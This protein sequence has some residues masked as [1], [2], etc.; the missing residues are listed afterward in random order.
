MDAPTVSQED[1]DREHRRQRADD[2]RRLA[3]RLTT[4]E[5][6]QQENSLFPADSKITY[7]IAEYAHR[8]LR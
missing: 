1:I 7:N 3:Q 4:P 2:E 8:H 6:L 5:Q